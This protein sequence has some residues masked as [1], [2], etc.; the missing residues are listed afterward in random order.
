MFSLQSFVL[1]LALAG[2]GDARAAVEHALPG[3]SRVRARVE[4]HADGGTE[5]TMELHYGGAMW[6]P[7]L[8]RLLAE[9][10][11][12]SRGRLLERLGARS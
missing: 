6:M 12:R 5:L 3:W 9:E 7:L 2:G 1:T 10:I 11:E 8:D 4:E